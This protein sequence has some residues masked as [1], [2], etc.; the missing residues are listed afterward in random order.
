MTS[1]ACV[2]PPLAA[3]PSIAN[4]HHP[5]AGLIDLGRRFQAQCAIVDEARR[6]SD[7]AHA[8]WDAFLEAAPAALRWTWARDKG[9][10]FACF[11][12]T[13]RDGTLY[14]DAVIEDL[15]T[16]LPGYKRGMTFPSGV[17]GQQARARANEI[18]R[19]FDKW[20]PGRDATA[21][22]L[23]CAD[24]DRAEALAYEE[25]DSIE[26]A[27]GDA[28]AAT[29][30]GLRIKAMVVDREAVRSKGEADPFEFRKLQLARL[31]LE[32]LPGQADTVPAAAE[33]SRRTD[34][35]GAQVHA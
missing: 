14:P 35:A 23:N 24:L 2:V 12:G 8:A 20:R 31:V 10:P 4:P 15:R 33:L 19:V 28:A 32:L 11:A 18:L 30:E 26:D 29:I 9:M 22:R 16:R 3:S 34:H 27:I 6:R 21:A 13:Q 5:D 7:E 17:T 1:V 25:I